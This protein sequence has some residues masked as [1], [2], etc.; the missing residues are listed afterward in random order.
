[1]EDLEALLFDTPIIPHRDWNAWLRRSQEEK[2]VSAEIARNLSRVKAVLPRIAKLVREFEDFQVR[3][4]ATRTLFFFRKGS[5]ATE[6]IIPNK[7][8]E[9]EGDTYAILSQIVL[10]TEK[11]YQE[12]GY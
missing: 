11:E 7:L 6:A 5:H 4:T 12:R 8:I 1:M 10:D 2:E 9:T 3:V